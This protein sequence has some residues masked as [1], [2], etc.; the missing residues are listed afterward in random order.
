MRAKASL[1]RRTALTGLLTAA[2]A[3]GAAGG[4]APAPTEAPPAPTTAPTHITQVQMVPAE[5]RLGTDTDVVIRASFRTRDNRPV[6][7]AQLQAVVNYPGGPRTFS[8]EQT[9]FPDG[10]LDYAIP[11]A[12]ERSNVQRG[13]ERRV[14]VAMKYQASECRSNSGFPVR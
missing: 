2:C 5:P 10:R 12:P 11:V 6:S 1:G 13:S 9:T 14:E 4:A 8:S 7:G 3:P